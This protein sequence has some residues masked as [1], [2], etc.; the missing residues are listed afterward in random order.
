MKPSDR[1]LRHLAVIDEAVVHVLI[2]DE[3][4][5]LPDNGNVLRHGIRQLTCV[6]KLDDL[7]HSLLA[8]VRGGG[9]RF[10]GRRFGFFVNNL[11]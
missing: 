7:R 8:V 10:V 9:Y 4:E 11:D 1:L 2:V 3:L 5:R 6:G